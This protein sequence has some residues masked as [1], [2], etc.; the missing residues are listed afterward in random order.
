MPIVV[1]DKYFTPYRPDTKPQGFVDADEIA[2]VK[3]LFISTIDKLEEDYNAGIF[4][5]Y[6]PMTTRYGVT[7]SNIEEAIRFIA[8]HEG[9]HF[10]Y[11]WA[12][13]RVV[14]EETT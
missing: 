13:K 8:F 9:L 10:G 6:Q 2:R 7:L 3:E 4:N 5:N 11:I 1:E 12:L 14:L